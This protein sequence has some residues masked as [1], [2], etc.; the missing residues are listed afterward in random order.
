[1]ITF[2]FF[3]SGVVLSYLICVISFS[4]F[5]FQP[6]YLLCNALM[7]YALSCLLCSAKTTAKMLAWQ[8]PLLII[9]AALNPI[10]SQYG[11]TLLAKIGPYNLYAESLLYGLCMGLML[12]SV[13]VWF[14]NASRM[15]N[16]DKLLNLFGNKLPTVTLM[17]S[18][19]LKFV[20]QFASEGKN[21]HQT[22]KA[23][24][25]A[26]TDK[27]N[28][29]HPSSSKAN[30]KHPSSSASTNKIVSSN[31]GEHHAKQHGLNKMKARFKQG[32]REITTLMANSMENSLETA[33]SM[34]ARGWGC[35]KKRSVYK[36]QKWHSHDTLAMI[37]ICALVIVNA[38]LAQNTCA[39]F[40]FYPHI[41]EPSMWLNSANC[42]GYI[43][44]LL[45]LCLPLLVHVIL[46][47]KMR[48]Q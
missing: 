42:I 7:G 22:L 10:F 45:F 5:A 14:A 13:M 43:L 1:M 33:D 11:T 35:S 8:I 3:H 9:I 20:P 41:S 38:F 32:M 31:I 28:G 30:G 40:S 16:A 25:P 46:R 19:V 29:E 47:A 34:R 17:T 23:N 12:I 36:L 26:H 2:D 6:I 48:M 24:M 4:F 37:I 44:Y 39:Q 21:I 27:T 15:L 18:M